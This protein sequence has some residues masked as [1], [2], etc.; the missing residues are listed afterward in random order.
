MGGG[1]RV[2]LVLTLSENVFEADDVDVFS[3][4][5][6][7]FSFDVSAIDAEEMV[8]VDDV[9][10]VDEQIREFWSPEQFDDGKEY[11]NVDPVDSEIDGVVYVVVV[12][13]FKVGTCR[14]S[15]RVGVVHWVLQGRSILSVGDA[16]LFDKSAVGWQSA[17]TE[18][19]FVCW[20]AECSKEASNIEGFKICIECMLS[21]VGECLT[22][23]IV[24]YLC[25]NCLCKQLQL[26]F[27]R[28]YPKNPA[29]IL[30][31]LGDFFWQFLFAKIKL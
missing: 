31:E 15:K 1:V 22:G 3:K 12:V 2:R 17:G 24:I 27:E 30:N 13:T 14:V 23:I 21:E 19:R 11:A 8:D 10:V 6:I 29:I 18:L 9:V 7:D 26:I 4:E 5:S 25:F 28:L 20:S 16:I